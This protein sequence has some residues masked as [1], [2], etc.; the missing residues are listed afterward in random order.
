M[1]STKQESQQLEHADQ[2]HAERSAYQRAVAFL[3]KQR[4]AEQ[5]G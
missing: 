4:Q 2:E 1:S 3:L 5:Q